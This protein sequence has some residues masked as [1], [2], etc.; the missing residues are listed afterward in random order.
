MSF[1]SFIHS[2]FTT[3]ET[4]N[5]HEVRINCPFCSDNKYHGYVNTDKKLYICHKCQISDNP[6]GKGLNG[7]QFI[8]KI[9]KG[10]HSQTMEQMEEE[11]IPNYD[12]SNQMILD[13]INAPTIEVVREPLQIPPYF[14]PINPNSNKLLGKRS[15]KYLKTR[16]KGKAKKAI[17]RYRIGYCFEGHWLGRIILPV[18]ENKNL[19]FYQGRSFYP[20]NRSPKYL[21]VKHAHPPVFGIKDCQPGGE[22]II[23]EGYFDVIAIGKGAVTGFG[24]K[25]SEDQITK[26]VSLKPSKVTVCFD[27]DDAGSKGYKKLCKVLDSKEITVYVTLNLEADPAELG[28]EARSIIEAQSVPTRYSSVLD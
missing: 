27:P 24:A 7:Y 22:I 23:C 21:N 5:K 10:T 16:L 17:K 3:L 8:K 4:G 15:W 12:D 19:V 13:N 9:Q 18:Y 6:L 20:A 2:R 14:K 11:G 28:L 25:M 1:Y 26:I